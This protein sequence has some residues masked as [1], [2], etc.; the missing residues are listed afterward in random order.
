MDNVLSNLT[1]YEGDHY[2]RINYLKCSSLVVV[3]RR[4]SNFKF[5]N[6]FYRSVF[7]S[8]LEFFHVSGVRWCVCSP[9][10]RF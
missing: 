7:W 2:N 1:Q 6:P 4:D 3:M 9:F 5:C 8:V 10:V